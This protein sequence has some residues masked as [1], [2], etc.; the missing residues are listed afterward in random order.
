M[1]L[2]ARGHTG[3]REEDDVEE[4]IDPET[5]T[6]MEPDEESPE[7]SQATQ[8]PP[9]EDGEG[10]RP[11]SERCAGRVWGCSNVRGGRHPGRTGCPGSSRT[12]FPAVPRERIAM[13]IKVNET[14][15]LEEQMPVRRGRIPTARSSSGEGPAGST[16]TGLETNAPTAP[17]S[18][19]APG[20]AAQAKA[21][22][23]A[24]PAK[25]SER[26][27]GSARNKPGTASGSRGG[28]KISEATEKT[29]PDKVAAHNADHRA[30]SKRADRAC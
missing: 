1:D 3:E 4:R 28:I 10:S 9:A 17:G 7:A 6:A 2:L 11:G 12:A 15:G 8:T 30:K 29:L 20:P 26:R 5:E 16:D 24:T 27:R 14:E 23:S 13:A 18:G 22:K 19:R 21:P 25:R